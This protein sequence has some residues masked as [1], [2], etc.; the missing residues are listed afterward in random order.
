MT[1]HSPMVYE[2]GLFFLA[3][4]FPFAAIMSMLMYGFEPGKLLWLAGALVASWL[5]LG[6]ARERRRR[7]K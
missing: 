7:R 3:L 6:A 2:Y 5:L 1:H 4:F